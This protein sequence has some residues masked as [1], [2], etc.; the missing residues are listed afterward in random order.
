MYHGRNI[1]RSACEFLQLF[2]LVLSTVGRGQCITK[3]SASGRIGYRASLHAFVLEHVLPNG[4]AEVNVCVFRAAA[5]LC[6]SG[7]SHYSL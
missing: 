6:G 7:S 4:V 5:W 2:L 1:I 3:Y